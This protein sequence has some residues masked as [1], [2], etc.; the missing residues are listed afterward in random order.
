M[1]SHDKIQYDIILA[2]CT[3]I[4]QSAKSLKDVSLFMCTQIM[5]YVDNSLRLRDCDV[6]T[7]KS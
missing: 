5:H 2:H 4:R 6:V 1:E 3:I 7:L